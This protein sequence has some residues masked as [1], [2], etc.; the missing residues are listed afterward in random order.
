LSI[1]I[2]STS[3]DE[4]APAANY[5]QGMATLVMEQDMPLDESS[6]QPYSD[7]SSDEESS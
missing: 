3:S 4:P 6:S 2:S 1:S 7:E 5:E